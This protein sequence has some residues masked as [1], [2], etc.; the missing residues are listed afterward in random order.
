MRTWK[1]IVAPLLVLVLLLSLTACGVAGRQ[2]PVKQQ[3]TAARGDLT[4][5]V[6]GNGKVAVTT[7]I[8][9]SFGNAGK[10]ALLNVKEGD[11]VTKGTLLARQDTASI[12]LALSQAKL[13]QSQAQAA[14]MQASA[15]QTTA[16]SALTAARFNLDRTQSVS[17]VNNA[18]TKIQNQIDIAQAN[19]SQA[20]SQGDTT[21]SAS[22]NRYI[23]DSQIALLLQKKKLS[24]L[25]TQTTYAGVDTY[26][27]AGQTYDR[28]T[29]E[30]IHI[31]ELAVESAQK[32]VDLA[33]QN[34]EV[35]KGALDQANS[36]VN[37]A[38]KAL[39]D[40]TLTAPF[41]GI[42]AHLY[43]KQGD[44]I[45][46]P[47]Y[48]PQNVVYIVDATNLEVDANID[49]MDVPTVKIG[50]NADI[51][52]DALPGVLIKGKVTS[53]AMIPN[54]QVAASGLTAYLAKV[55][56]TVSPEQGIKPGMN[57]TVNV[58]TNEKKN[59][60]LLPIQAVKKDSQGKSYV[61]VPNG[62][63]TE[64]RTVTIGIS[65]GSQVEIVSGI[66]AGDKVVTSE[67]AGKWSLQGN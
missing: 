62:D 53:I 49:E 24:L 38:Q 39:N 63:K 25:L 31:K 51:S 5:K 30:D 61:E 1:V 4:V 7:D 14:V 43:Y 16:E 2:T 60:V 17:D 29:L 40:A 42:V 45:P 64:T 22:L 15:A 35:A 9:L 18:I 19:L 8:N 11:F 12:E 3:I 27:I 54:T 44:I 20:Q 37:V 66:Q 10:L 21:S 50:Q 52:I 46:S 36:A 55:N 28:L 47:A 23:Q 26:N 33:K 32:S 34:I 58:V 41:D 65:S 13:G 6:S 67:T 59:V 48:T 57:A 56:F